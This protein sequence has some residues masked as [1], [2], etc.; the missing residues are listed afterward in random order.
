MRNRH[1]NNAEI[2]FTDLHGHDDRG[3]SIFSAFLM[4]RVVFVRPEITVANDLSGFRGGNF[5]E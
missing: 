1:D 5:H 4:T 3:W 2:V